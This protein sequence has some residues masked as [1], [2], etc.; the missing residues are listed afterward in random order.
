[1]SRPNLNPPIEGLK[2]LGSPR[3]EK[4]DAQAYDVDM[5]LS[6]RLTEPGRLGSLTVSMTRVT[7]RI[8]EDCK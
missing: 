1:M 4:T 8:L 6:R 3:P 7:A 2:L 5:A